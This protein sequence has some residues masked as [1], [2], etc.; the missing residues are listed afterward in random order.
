[1]WEVDNSK[2]KKKL[3]KDAVPTIFGESVYQVKISDE[4]GKLMTLF[5]FLL[6]SFTI[7]T[8]YCSK[9]TNTSSN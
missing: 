7:Y 9:D 8:S 5:S 2:A 6:P 1:M 3:K 4:I